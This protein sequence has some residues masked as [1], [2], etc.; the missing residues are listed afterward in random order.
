MELVSISEASRKLGYS[1]RS[2]LYQL[3]DQGWLNDFLLINKRGKRQLKMKGLKEYVRSIC[4]QRINNIEHRE[5]EAIS[6]ESWFAMGEAAN[7]VMAEFG[8]TVSSPRTCA[9]WSIIYE[10]MEKARKGTQ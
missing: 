7:Q 4:Q 6:L 10:A 9:E 5:P 8:W 3:I 2:Q 1:S